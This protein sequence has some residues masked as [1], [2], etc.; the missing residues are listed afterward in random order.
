MKAK[1]D[2]LQQAQWVLD[3]RPVDAF[4]AARTAHGLPVRP[5]YAE[6]YLGKVHQ[7]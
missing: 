6:E 4:V 1:L 7:A 5:P 3:I 2:S